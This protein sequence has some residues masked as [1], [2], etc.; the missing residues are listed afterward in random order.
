MKSLNRR[1]AQDRNGGIEGLPLQLMIVILIATMGTAILVG[2]MGNIDTPTSIGEVDVASGD[3]VLTDYSSSNGYYV[4]LYVYD[5]EGNPLQG[6]TVVLSGL[7][8]KS[9]GQTAYGVTNANGYL[10]LTHLDIR[11]GNNNVG[12][13]TVNVSMANYGENNSARITVIG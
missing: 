11:M 3:I 2:W 10:K 7:G 9:D 4:E 1:L 5:N 6:A 8:V 12:F 13:I